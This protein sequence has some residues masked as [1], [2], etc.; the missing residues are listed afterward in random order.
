MGLEVSTGFSRI[1]ESIVALMRFSKSEISLIHNVTLQLSHYA[2]LALKRKPTQHAKIREQRPLATLKVLKENRCSKKR[3]QNPD[4]HLIKSV[5]SD[6]ISAVTCALMSLEKTK[7]VVSLYILPNCNTFHMILRGYK[8]YQIVRKKQTIYPA[9]SNSDILV[10]STVIVY[11]IHISMKRSGDITHRC[12]N[13]APTVNGCDLTPPTRTQT[14]EQ[15]YSDL[16]ASNRRSS[17]PSSRN[18]P[19]RFSRRT[20]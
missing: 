11:S 19:E 14:S 2:F 17:T 20:G 10:D 9:A 3:D 8:Q 7:S 15:E 12:R 13:P 5:V 18:I 16:T 4:I 1:T 6:M